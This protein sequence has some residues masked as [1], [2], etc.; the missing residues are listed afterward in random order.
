M[1]WNIRKWWQS[2]VQAIFQFSVKFKN[3]TI[4][5]CLKFSRPFF[6]LH[7]QVLCTFF[8]LHN[9]YTKVAQINTNPTTYKPYISLH[10]LPKISLKSPIFMLGKGLFDEL[11]PVFN[12]YIY[13]NVDAVSLVMDSLLLVITCIRTRFCS[14]GTEKILL[15]FIHIWIV[16]VRLNL[17]YKCNLMHFIFAFKI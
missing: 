12:L 5:G 13:L 8:K 6:L 17:F 1:D 2:K 9:I 10:I 3:C 16:K 15:I 4:C 7:I 14:K 11:S